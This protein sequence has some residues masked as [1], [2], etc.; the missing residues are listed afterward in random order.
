MDSAIHTLNNRYDVMGLIYNW[1]AIYP[2]D[3][4]LSILW[5]NSLVNREKIHGGNAGH[6]SAYSYLWLMNLISQNFLLALLEVVKVVNLNN[7]L[8]YEIPSGNEGLL[9]FYSDSRAQVSY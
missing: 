9:T 5:T 2:A 4:K 1:I 6:I 8:Q 3:K 7:S